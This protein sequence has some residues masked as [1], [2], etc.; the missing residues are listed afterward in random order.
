[1][2]YLLQQ[3]RLPFRTGQIGNRF[4][5]TCDLL[6]I[7]AEGSTED[8]ARD[9]LAAALSSCLELHGRLGMLDQVLQES[10]LD[11]IHSALLPPFSVN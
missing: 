11:P 8:E 10:G 5:C 3:I 1:M 2:M 7:Q 9:N 6:D 4:F